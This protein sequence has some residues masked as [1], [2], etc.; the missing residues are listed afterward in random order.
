MVADNCSL[1]CVHCM[2]WLMAA[3]DKFNVDS[4]I[5]RLLEGLALSSY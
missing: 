3:D 5:Q 1:P 2:L 4:V